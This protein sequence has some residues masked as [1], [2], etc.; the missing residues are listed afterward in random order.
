MA[1]WSSQ[2]KTVDA[3]PS[4]KVIRDGTKD[5]MNGHTELNQNLLTEQYNLEPE[6]VGTQR[7]QHRVQITETKLATELLF[8]ENSQQKSF[9]DLKV[10][11]GLLLISVCCVSVGQNMWLLDDLFDLHYSSVI[12][13]SLNAS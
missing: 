4:V 10:Y 11:S 13:S 2:P 8:S 12:C 3:K 9:T 7:N 6:S 1:F 5:N